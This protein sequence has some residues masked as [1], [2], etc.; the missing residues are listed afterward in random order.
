MPTAH[1]N[2]G[3]NLGNRRSLLETAVALIEKALDRPARRSVII[4][5]EPWGYDSPNPF[6]NMGIAVECG[7]LSAVE[8]HS[9][10][11][12]LQRS[13][14]SSSHRTESGAYADRA[15]D[16]DLIAIGQEVVAIPE[17]TLPHPRMH[18][19]E[20]VLRPMEELE[21]NWTHP[22]LG[23]TPAEMLQKLDSVK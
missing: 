3:S 4:E 15:I 5:S 11:Q 10:L 6:L 13:I 18:L 23:L 8:V 12:K 20:F 22:L 2:I 21:P 17:L 9:L 19:R 1:I 16:I 7:N 14:D